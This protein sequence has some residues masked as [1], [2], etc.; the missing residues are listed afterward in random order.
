M[1]GQK[2]Q[3]TMRKDI[4]NTDFY[5]LK[6]E[7]SAQKTRISVQ[8]VAKNN[9]LADFRVLTKDIKAV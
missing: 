1:I 6:R 3:R 9:T 8:S 7:F 5:I 2:E 4:L